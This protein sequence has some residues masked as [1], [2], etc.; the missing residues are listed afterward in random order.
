MFAAADMQCSGKKTRWSVTYSI[1][2]DLHGFVLETFDITIL[3]PT[4]TERDIPFGPPL[5]LQ[6]LHV[7]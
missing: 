5:A 7:S 1:L 4:A 6:T 3:S 2:L